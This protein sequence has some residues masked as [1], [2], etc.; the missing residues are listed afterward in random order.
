MAEK[1]SKRKMRGAVL[2]FCVAL[3]CCGGSS[4]N[5]ERMLIVTEAVPVEFRCCGV[6]YQLGEGVSSNGRRH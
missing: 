6:W 5:S 3:A 1:D 4:K 2:C